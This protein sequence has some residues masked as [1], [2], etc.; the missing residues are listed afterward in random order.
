MNEL[1][2]Q[3]YIVLLINL[4]FYSGAFKLLTT[5]TRLVYQPSIA[6]PHRLL[7]FQPHLPGPRVCVAALGLARQ[8]E[9]LHK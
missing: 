6:E 2:Y 4:H 3:S 8:V 9:R 7:I 5:F 1:L